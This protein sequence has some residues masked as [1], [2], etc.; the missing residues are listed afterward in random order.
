VGKNGQQLRWKKEETDFC[1]KNTYRKFRK[2][3]H[4]VLP[5]IFLL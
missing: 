3:I 1:A 4:P 2:D 5:L